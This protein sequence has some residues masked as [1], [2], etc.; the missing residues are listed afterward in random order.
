MPHNARNALSGP[1]CTSSALSKLICALL[2]DGLI[3]ALQGQ[4]SSD[5]AKYVIKDFSDIDLRVESGE[6]SGG[7]SRVEEGISILEIPNL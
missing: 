5:V 3:Q 4:I 2:P 6:F 1:V 7:D